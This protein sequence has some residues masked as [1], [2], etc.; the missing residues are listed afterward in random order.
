[1]YLIA[2]GT[3]QVDTVDGKILLHEGDFFGEMA[4]LTRERR[5]A[6]VTA[7]KSTDLL[8]LDCD[9]FHR[10]IDRNPDVGARVRA[11]AQQRKS[12]PVT[13]TG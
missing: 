7:I 11:V 2:S 6:T 9:D 4:L 5:T 8:V 13:R 1:M 10:F 12:E 3:V